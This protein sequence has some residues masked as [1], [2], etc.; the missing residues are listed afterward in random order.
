ML[1]LKTLLDIMS[2]FMDVIHSETGFSV[3]IF[4]DKGDIIMATDKASIGD[5]HAGAEKI[6]R[7]E[8]D[9]Y[10]VTAQ[11]AAR[12]P[13]TKEGYICAIK[14]SGNKIGA[15][16]IIGE[17]AVVTPV[18]KISARMMDSWIGQME[19]QEKLGQA[20]KKFETIFNNLQDVYFETTLEG[21]VITSSPS[22]A[23]FSGY[24][25]AEII[26]HP[27]DMLY[28]NPQDRQLLLRQLSDNGQVRGLEMLF[29]RKDGSV[30]D[31]SIN[32]NI[33][34]DDQGNPA[35]L[36]G[37]IRDITDRK[38]AERNLQKS[39]AKF[40][41]I[42]EHAPLGIFHFSKKGLITACNDNFSKIIGS[43]KEVLTGLNM[44]MLPDDRIVNRLKAALEGNASFFEGDYQSTTAEKVTP[45]RVLFSPVFSKEGL[46]DG[47]IGIVEDVTDPKKARAEL[48]ESERR[49]R[50]LAELL[51]ETIY[52]V[53]LQGR[54]TFV[55]QKAFKL[56]GY[57]LDDFYKGINVMELISEK[58]RERASINVRKILQGDPPGMNE[59][60][61]QR[62]DGTFFPALLHSS[63]IYENDEAIGMRGFLI[64]ITEKKRTQE[65]LIQNEKMM[66]I[67]GLAAGMAHEINNPLAG[68]IQNAQVAINRLTL[69]LPGNE[70]A[71]SEAGT[72]LPAIRAYMEKRGILQQLEHINMAG[73][74]AAKIVNNMLGFAKKRE[75]VKAPE[76]LAQLIDKTLDLLKSDYN[77]KKEYDFKNIDIIKQIDPDVPK[78]NC[79]ESKIQQV[80]LNIIKNSIEAVMETKTIKNLSLH[81]RLTTG[82]KKVCLEI[83]DNG[84]GIEYHVRKRI[85][86]PFFTTK[87][88]DK[89]TGL[90]LSLSYFIIVEDHKGELEVES[91]PGK[92]TKFII[93]LPVE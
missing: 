23:V 56:F 89:G 15:F 61:L 73:H 29:K 17:L 88:V 79:E 45:V 13:L 52:E 66:S 77:L 16:G 87:S 57:T 26:G 71:A 30:Y 2:Q 4:D 33:F 38:K 93:Q 40:R 5:H 36:K 69:D 72:S 90:G 35:G 44:L 43:S 39:E 25:L 84:P 55:N 1:I 81:F 37:T 42:F 22:G 51:P 21:M 85:F 78:V 74:Q 68:M 83:E 92:G 27:V 19:S 9:E 49:F 10:A 65:I 62:K 3:L 41:L 50:E 7:G 47:G 63:L 48:I 20:E 28:N 12:N 46:P 76:D 91:T 80:V 75:S 24:P 59:Y 70:A 53:D 54:I 64:D 18:A 86:E 58:D 34:F 32:A 82:N 31:V 8:E 67:G 11:E 60:E 14:A 6:L